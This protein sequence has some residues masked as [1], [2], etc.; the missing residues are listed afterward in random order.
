MWLI[1]PYK[2]YTGLE[3]ELW[4]S[5]DKE[6]VHTRVSTIGREVK[7]SD[8]ILDQ[9]VEF[10]LLP[11]RAEEALEVDDKDRGKAP[12]HVALADVHGAFAVAAN[13]AF[14]IGDAFLLD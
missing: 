3:A 9:G 2:A 8:G 7:A 14:N 6:D 10:L 11:R 12:D 5:F 13:E 1:T 4:A